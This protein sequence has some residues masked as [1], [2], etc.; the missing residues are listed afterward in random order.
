MVA[1]AR[2]NESSN[3]ITLVS[4]NMF[5][6]YERTCVYQ[7]LPRN[8]SIIFAAATSNAIVNTL[9]RSPSGTT[10]ITSAG[11]TTSSSLQHTTTEEGDYQ[12]CA[13]VAIPSKVYLS[14]LVNKAGSHSSQIVWHK[15]R[16]DEDAEIKHIHE[17]IVSM[18]DHLFTK[19]IHLK[20]FMRMHH[21]VTR[22]DDELQQWN[23]GFIVKYVMVFCIGAII[24][25]VVEVMLIRRMFH[26]DPKRLRI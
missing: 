21:L 3:P 24:V 8:L 16:G 22:R 12:F 20:V 10:T 6:D 17:D 9:L 1:V 19:T 25:A 4:L 7:S 18:L 14:L 26:R 23:G 2:F 5:V 15:L 13:G 11:K